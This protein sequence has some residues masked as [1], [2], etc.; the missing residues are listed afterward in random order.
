MQLQ[1]MLPM[2]QRLLL[3]MLPTPVFIPSIQSAQPIFLDHIV[4]CLT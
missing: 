2:M 1:P 4:D 3:M